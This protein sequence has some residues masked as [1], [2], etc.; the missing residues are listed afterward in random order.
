MS[1]ISIY[2]HVPFCLRKCGY[3]DFF[4]V[5][6]ARE[7]VPHEAY[8]A[9]LLRQLRVDVEVLGLRGRD[10][11]TVYFGGGT[12]SLLPSAFFQSLLEELARHVHL[13]EDLEVSCEANPG[14]VDAAWLR[15][16]RA[17]G[18]TR[19][20][21]GVQTFQPRLLS[22][23]GR[24]HAAEDAMR[25]IAEAQDAGFASVGLDLMYGLPGETM[26]ELEDDLRTAMT[27]QPQHLSAYQLTLE[28]GTP[29]YEGLSESRVTSH[30]S[31]EE[32]ALRQMRTVARMLS[33]SG[34]PRYEIS[35]FAKH[36]F[37]CR[38]NLNY[39][40]YGEYLGLGAGATSFLRMPDRGPGT[41]NRE[42]DVE[43]PDPRSPVP[44]PAFARRWTQSRDV[45]AYVA[46]TA[47]PAEDE[48]IPIRTAMAEYCFLG[49][50]TAEGISPAAFERLFGLPVKDVFGDTLRHLSRDGLLTMAK[51]HFTLTTRGLEISNRVFADFLP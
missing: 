51:E 37:E 24:V 22:A 34:W 26:G 31:R 5:P 9:A 41:R 27:F 19:L 3:C 43:V 36:G 17:A 23:L 45:A 29:M 44:D 28:P 49:L 46:G 4:S 6:M 35:N 11:A 33:R 32:L 48:T 39:W 2:I 7:E 47:V 40:R 21:I 25:A 20:S 14:T 10:V 1:A 30:E 38:H 50:R 13:Q 8:L 12:P 16:A 18:V 42:D 15:E